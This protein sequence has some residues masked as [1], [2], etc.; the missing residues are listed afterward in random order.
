MAPLIVAQSVEGEANDNDV[1]V[2]THCYGNTGKSGSPNVSVSAMALLVRLIMHWDDWDVVGFFTANILQDGT[3]EDTTG[4]AEMLH[5]VQEVN[6]SSIC[7]VDN[8]SFSMEIS[9]RR[10]FQQQCTTS[11][12]SDRSTLGMDRLQAGCPQCRLGRL[13]P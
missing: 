10:C 1:T 9:R 6:G 7:G 12:C 3:M 11:T 8:S 13:L 4:G 5:N 2:C